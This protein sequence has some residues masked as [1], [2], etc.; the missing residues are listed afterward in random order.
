MPEAI[1]K[2]VSLLLL[3]FVGFLISSKIKSKEQREGV[4]TLILSIA[5]PATIFIALLKVEFTLELVLVPLLAVAFNFVMYFLISKLPLDSLFNIQQNQYRTLMLIIP[6]L[7]PGLSVFPFILEYSGEGMLA[8]AAVADLGNKIFVLIIAYII[9]MRWYYKFNR[10]FTGEGKLNLKDV[11]KALINEPVNL[12]VVTAIILLTVGIKFDAF[13]GFLQSGIDKLSLMMTPLVLLFIGMSV[14][15][16]WTQ[17]RTIL[18]FLFFR[19]G[20]AFLISAVL[21]VIIAPNDLGTA[22]LIVIF[23]QSA[24]SFWPYA[25][26][27]VVSKLEASHGKSTG[28]FDLDFAMNILACSLPFSVLLVMVVYTAQTTFA[29]A[30]NVTGFGALCLLLAAAPALVPVFAPKSQLKEQ[31]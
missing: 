22:L 26:M 12:V 25:H 2:T 9:A 27:A 13:P 24:C 4:R 3:I 15:F 18:A 1:T 20:V 29:S 7:A 30:L 16:T 5:L 19:S 14:K 21:L 10:E 28:T 6:S 11:L 8:M 31:A 17:V 23:P